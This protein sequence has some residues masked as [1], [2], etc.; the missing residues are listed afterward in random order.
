L[1]NVTGVIPV[2][3]DLLQIT[4]RAG[5]ASAS[6]DAAIPSRHQ[7]CESVSRR[8]GAAI[9]MRDIART[10]TS[11]RS[12]HLRARDRRGRAGRRLATRPGNLGEACLFIGSG[13]PVV[14]ASVGRSGQSHV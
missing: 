13:S 9:A 12:P 7:K 10:Y 4:P 11:G 14:C 1:I 2:F 3:L 8:T 6:K 5:I